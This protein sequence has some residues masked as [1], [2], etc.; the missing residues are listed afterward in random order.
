V[1]AFDLETV[2]QRAGVE[3]EFVRQLV[4]LRV[5]VPDEG[6]RMTEG[7]TRRVSIVYGLDQAGL[8]I[9]SLAEAM[10]RGEISLD[11]VDSPSYARFASREGPTFT[12]VSDRTGIPVDL[13]RLIRDAMGFAT[14]QPSDRMRSD[15][16]A[17]VPLLEVEL[18]QGISH[19]AIERSLRVSGDSLRR[20]AETEAAW[21]RDEIMEPLFRAGTPGSEIGPL[22]AGF[23]ARLAGVSDEALL[24]LYHARQS[25]AWLRNIFEGFELLLANAGLHSRLEQPPAIC[26]LDLSG[27]TR[28]TEQQGDQAAADLAS[29]LSRLV[30]RTSGRHGGR[31]IKWLGD[32]VMFYFHAPGPAVLAALE[33]VE[34]AAGEGLPPAHVGLHAG[35]VL[36][37]EGDYFG[38]TVNA[39]ARIADFARPGE[40]LVS[41]EVVDASDVPGVQFAPIGPIELKGLAGPLSL[42]SA[43]RQA[44]R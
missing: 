29:R 18:A 28:L 39:T 21:W 3:P 32:G 5:V 9:A 24:A 2:A 33:M 25:D 40:L 34:G 12:E 11:F 35:P 17:V 16:L 14:A 15:E 31:P 8:P 20:I 6:G 26:F 19:A 42:Y 7:D 4:E 1:S 23:A 27:Y 41:Q 44:A 30:E 37:Q 10:R 22:T 13:L 38:R 43:A 36:F